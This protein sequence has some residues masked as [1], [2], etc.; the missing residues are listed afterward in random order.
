MTYYSKEL[1]EV[2]VNWPGKLFSEEQKVSQKSKITLLLSFWKSASENFNKFFVLFRISRIIF[3]SDAFVNSQEWTL[4]QGV[5][6]FK[7]VST[8]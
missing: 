3:T 8:L 7:L 6:E 4:S 1:F 5:A 2:V